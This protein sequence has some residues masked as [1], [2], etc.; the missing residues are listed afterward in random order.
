MT[1]FSGMVKSLDPA[2]ADEIQAYRA[3]L[4]KHAPIETAEARFLERKDDL[5][6]VAP[7]RRA[8]NNSSGGGGGAAAAAG[9]GGGGVGPH[10][11]A[12]VGLPLIA[13]LPLMSFGIVPG[14]LGRLFIVSLIGAGEVLVVTSSELMGL[15]SVREWF[16]CASM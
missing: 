4:E 8:T 10:Q 16:V 5:L 6:A 2:S 3:W 12:A 11:R 15:M 1:S 7:Q 13:V 14:L 9:G